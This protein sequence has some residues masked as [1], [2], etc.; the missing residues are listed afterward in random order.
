MAEPSEEV[1]TQQVDRQQ[2]IKKLCSQGF[3]LTFET[4]VTLYK[5]ELSSPTEEQATE[6]NGSEA[7]AANATTVEPQQ[8]QT[9]GYG[10][11][12]V[13][14]ESGSL[15]FRIYDVT[16]GEIL[17]R[18]SLSEDS[19]YSE[20]SGHFHAFIDCTS[21]QDVDKAHCFGISTPD[22]AVAKK[23]LAAVNRTIPH[24]G[25][26]LS[27]LGVPPPKRGRF[28][29]EGIDD[30]WVI[31]EPA[32]V[33]EAQGES[34]VMDDGGSDDNETD[35]GLVRLR[36]GMKR[37]RKSQEKKTRSLIISEP[38]EFRHI[39]HVGQE[40]SVSNMTK[41]MSV[42]ISQSQ[43][44]SSMGGSLEPGTEETTSFYEVPQEDL[45]TVAPPPAPP[46]PT[47]PPPPPIVKPPAPIIIGKKRSSGTD[48]L[49]P[50][51]S[52]NPAIS[53]DEILRTR[54]TLRPV[55]GQKVVPEPPPKP[56]RTKLASEINTFDRNTL[57]HIDP[58]KDKDST[59]V[60]DPNCLQS[61]LRA[62]LEKMREKLS[63]DFSNLGIVDSKGDE[64]GF[65]D[66]CDGPLFTEE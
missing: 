58:K 65:V 66:E 64:Y 56:D 45:P 16:S 61:I 30:D 1:P 62:G 9:V 44:I 18:F 55:G 43:D 14:V 48:T 54:G 31:I 46:A 21:L 51:Q 2:I 5:Y 37:R 15:E 22:E 52:Q 25:R 32:D 26:S 10:I 59:D 41:A 8:W 49:K 33:L 29:N 34:V 57:K 12:V 36:P 4:A 3:G 63:T 28:E 23:I 27:E 60:D 20:L 7:S 40:T 13:A 50:S 39:A 19:C 6:A 47:P 38:K 11:P 17:R 42:N 24:A 35:S 53:L